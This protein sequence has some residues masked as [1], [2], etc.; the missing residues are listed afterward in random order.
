MYGQFQPQ[1]NLQL[2]GVPIQLGVNTFIQYNDLFK[3][4]DFKEKK[5][6]QIKNQV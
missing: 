2:E 6:D 3:T 1:S 4:Q 5:N